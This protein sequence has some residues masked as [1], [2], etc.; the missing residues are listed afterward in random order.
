MDGRSIRVSSQDD[1]S[2]SNFIRTNIA[3]N[4]PCCLGVDKTD[5]QTRHDQEDCEFHFDYPNLTVRFEL[6]I[7][8]YFRSLLFTTEAC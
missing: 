7:K 1:P 5:A 6:I 8:I 3:Q 4:L 2:A